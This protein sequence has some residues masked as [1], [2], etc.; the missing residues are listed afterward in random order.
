MGEAV[1]YMKARI[2]EGKLEPFKKFMAEALDAY[3]YWQANRGKSPDQFWPSFR[4]KFP[5][6]TLFLQ[7][8]CRIDTETGDCNNGLS[9][10][11]SFGDPEDIENIS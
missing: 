10:I 3:A 7:R 4:E 5:V 1:Y 8:E 9:G 6:V 11:L 2:D